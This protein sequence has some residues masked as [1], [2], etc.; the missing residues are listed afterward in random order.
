MRYFVNFNLLLWKTIRSRGTGPIPI[1]FAASFHLHT[2]QRFSPF[3]YPAF[4]VKIKREILLFACKPPHPHPLPFPTFTSICTDIGP[5]AISALL[6]CLSCP[7]HSSVGALSSPA[8]IEAIGC[9]WHSCRMKGWVWWLRT[10][11]YCRGGKWRLIKFFDD[12][13]LCWC[14]L[15]IRIIRFEATQSIAVVALA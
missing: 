6:P 1:L 14:C 7:S 13:I 2:T 8:Q 15:L 12:L 5:Y 3:L 11:S 10:P 9:W 4:D